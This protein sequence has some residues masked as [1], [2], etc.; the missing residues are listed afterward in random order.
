M[1]AEDDGPVLLSRAIGLSSSPYPGKKKCE[2]KK[3]RSISFRFISSFS[4]FL[5]TLTGQFLTATDCLSLP[6]FAR[7]SLSRIGQLFDDRS[8]L[9]W[10]QNILSRKK[11][12][13][14]SEKKNSK[15]EEGMSGEK[16]SALCLIEQRRM[17]RHSAS[18]D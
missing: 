17:L 11:G 15:I 4:F 10:Q 2:K 18:P 9:F 7:I 16:R 5:P 8:H 12:G 6:P 14:A 1:V 13:L 3:E